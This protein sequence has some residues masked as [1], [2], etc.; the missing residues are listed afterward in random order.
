MAC[1]ELLLYLHMN[2][3]YTSNGT[4]RN[5]KSES[6]LI[7]CAALSLRHPY[8]H[9]TLRKLV[10]EHRIKFW[11]LSQIPWECRDMGRIFVSRA[12]RG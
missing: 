2:R 12:H 3:I 4:P 11:N 9:V 5:K 6:Q 7:A 10:R 1:L 8:K